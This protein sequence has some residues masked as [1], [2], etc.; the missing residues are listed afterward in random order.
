MSMASRGGKRPG[1]GR[2]SKWNCETVTLRVPKALVSEIQ[3]FIERRMVATDGPPMV[4]EPES[5]ELWHGDNRCQATTTKGTRCHSPA[6]HVHKLQ[7]GGR[8]VE[9]GICHLHRDQTRQGIDVRVHPS[10]LDS[11]AKSNQ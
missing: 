4:A 6:S 9:I 8:S 11:V 10:I 5:L 3:D 7:H 2:K 1:A